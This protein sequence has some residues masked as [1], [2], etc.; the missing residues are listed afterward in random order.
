MGSEVCEARGAVELKQPPLKVVH[1]VRQFHPSVGGLEDAVL[2][3]VR[4][5]RRE[6]GI[7][8]RVVTLDRLFTRPKVVLPTEDVVDGIPVRRLRW[9]GSSRY[10]VAPSVLGAIRGADLVHV[11]AI[12]FFFDFLAL[13][14]VLHGIPLVASTHGGFFHSSFATRAKRTYFTLV[15]RASCLAYRRIIACSD[16][17]AELFRPIVGDGRLVT[18]ENGVDLAKFAGAASSVPTR[19]ILSYGRFARHKRVHLLFQLLAAL[20]QHDRSWRLIVAG[21]EADATLTS[22]EAAASTACV[23]D[24]VRFVLDP[25]NAA[26]RA[27]MGEASYYA[28]A[29]EHEGFGI[30]AVEGLS[31]GLVPLLNDIGPF[32]K[33]INDGG[34]GETLDMAAPAAASLRIEAG[35]PGM[36]GRGAHARAAASGYGWGGVARSYAAAYAASRT[37][38]S[39]EALEVREVEPSDGNIT[40]LQPRL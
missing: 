29:S 5:Q 27:L 32:R 11:H 18:I 12:D 6:L 40:G 1:V 7:D 21:S 39:R 2:N 10:P 34:V 26:L 13:T 22:L 20:Q 9:R 4:V 36:E 15:T 19:T 28:S 24:A 23:T 30:A 3:L 17:D 31:A 38:V 16:S 8:A 25:S 37:T 33:L 14:R 35:H